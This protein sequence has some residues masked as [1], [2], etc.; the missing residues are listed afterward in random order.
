MIWPSLH[1]LEIFCHVVR[2]RSMARAAE[3]LMVTPSSISMQIQ[4]LERRFGT[5]LVVR[6]ARGTVP[7]STGQAVYDFASELFDRFDT[8]Q[9]EIASK[10]MLESGLLRIASGHTIGTS[11]IRPALQT[12]SGEH[13]EIEVSHFMLSNSERA[14]TEVLE[15]RAEIALI[16]RVDPDW[17]VDAEPLVD[18]PLLIT[19]SPEHP[20]ASLEAPRAQD[21]AGFPILLR[22]KYV[23]GSE[24]VV[25]ALARLGVRP[26]VTEL[27]STEA[28]KAYARD[29]KGIAILPATV[30]TDDVTAGT[31]VARTFSDFS[32][33][34]T[35]YLARLPK[36]PLTV[37]AEAFVELIRIRFGPRG[38]DDKEKTPKEKRQTPIVTE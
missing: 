9:R 8:L 14:K 38:R 13:P 16:G 36:T 24:Q 30:V 23:L 26:E 4:Q 6:S 31:L 17:P 37:C 1:Q 33:R 7:T 18:E 10:G 3:L 34:R 29:G 20:L 19:M 32:P 12:F 35:V 5:T 22:R 28:V 25:D 11:V 15:G 27:G 2:F 21:L